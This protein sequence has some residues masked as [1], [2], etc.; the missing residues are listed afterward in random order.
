MK[1]L[2]IKQHKN[3]KA[4]DFGYLQCSLNL[5]PCHKLSGSTS[6][7]PFAGACASV[8]LSWC[9]HNSSML[10]K[11]ALPARIARTE[12]Y[13][14]D[15]E[16]FLSQ[17]D[18]ELDGFKKLASKKGLRPVCQLNGLSD[19]WFS[20]GVM[21]NHP[22]IQFIDYTKS[23]YKMY[24]LWPRN[25]HLT[26]SIN[27]KTPS[28]LVSNIYRDTRFNAAF[29]WHNNDLPETYSIDGREYKVIDG[30]VHNLR[31]LDEPGC[32][33][34]LRLKIPTLPAGVA[35]DMKQRAIDLGFVRTK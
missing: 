3:D 32:L 26:Y 28:G 29:V 35:A 4:Q 24:G 17:L 1:L 10:N 31:F 15:Y 16:G 20:D 6:T 11:W 5:Q 33:V 18:K 30:D 22:S 27:E 14:K 23:Q 9:G 13:D 8:C 21:R 34:G 7:C 12:F 25:Y 19:V 2:T